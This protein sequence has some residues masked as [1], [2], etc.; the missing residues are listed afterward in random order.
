MTEDSR[1]NTGRHRVGALGRR[2][3]ARARRQR[4]ELGLGV[5]LRLLHLRLRQ[6]PAELRDL[7]PQ[8]AMIS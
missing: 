3:L 6:L 4:R 7:G 1:P 2:P 5:R 8:A